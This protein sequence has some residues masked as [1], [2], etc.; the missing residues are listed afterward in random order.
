MTGPWQPAFSCKPIPSVWSQTV[1][2]DV[3]DQAFQAGQWRRG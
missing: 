1:G 2:V 3:N